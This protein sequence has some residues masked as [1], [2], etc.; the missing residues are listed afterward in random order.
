MGITLQDAEKFF[1]QNIKTF[2]S[3]T[4][5]ELAIGQLDF[6]NKLARYDSNVVL[7][8]EA[9]KQ[10]Y[11]QLLINSFWICANTSPI[12]EDQ[13]SALVASPL[14]KAE[15]A[16]T[17]GKSILYAAIDFC[18]ERNIDLPLR[19]ILQNQQ[20]L[21]NLQIKDQEGSLATDYAI[22]N[23]LTSLALKTLLEKKARCQF[24]Y[25][26]LAHIQMSLD[27]NVLNDVLSL[28]DNIN[29]EDPS[30]KQTLAN[31]AFQ[32]KNEELLF[33]MI[34]NGA[35][36][37]INTVEGGFKGLMDRVEI[38]AKR[39]RAERF[40]YH[41]LYQK[42]EIDINASLNLPKLKKIISDYDLDF[43]HVDE[44]KQ[45]FYTTQLYY[46]FREY[47]K[48]VGN[49]EHLKVIILSPFFKAMNKR[50]VEMLSDMAVDLY[51]ATS[52]NEEPLEVLLSLTPFRD[53]I[54][55]KHSQFSCNITYLPFFKKLLA[56]G[57]KLSCR[58]E[59]LQFAKQQLSPSEFNAFL[60]AVDNINDLMPTV[61]DKKN[62]ELLVL[63]HDAKVVL[64]NPD[65]MKDIDAI[66]LTLN[67]RKDA[68]KFYKNC[69]MTDTNKEFETFVISELRQ[70]KDAFKKLVA[71]YDTH[72]S[73]LDEK[74]QLH[75]SRLLIN[76]FKN[77]LKNPTLDLEHLQAITLSPY[78]KLSQS[79]EHKKIVEDTI[80][81]CRKKNDIPMQAL[82]NRSSFFYDFINNK[83]YYEADFINDELFKCC[84]KSQVK[85]HNKYEELSEMRKKYTWDQLQPVLNA[86]KNINA[87]DEKGVSL[88]QH[89]MQ[90]NDYAFLVA[91]HKA[92][93]NLDCTMEIGGIE[94][95]QEKVKEENLKLEA[96][97]FYEKDIR[98]FARFTNSELALDEKKFQSLVSEYDKQVNQLNQEYKEVYKKLILNSIDA[99]IENSD[100]GKPIN[101]LINSQYFDLLGTTN[102]KPIIHEIIRKFNNVPKS[103][104]EIFIKHK[105]ISA[106]LKI[107]D[108][109]G[110]L[111]ANALYKDSEKLLLLT[112]IG[113]KINI[114]YNTLCYI[115]NSYHFSKLIMAM[116]SHTNLQ[117]IDNHKYTFAEYA[118][119]ANDYYMLNALHRCQV[120]VKRA[121]AMGGLECVRQLKY[122][123]E[124]AFETGE[125]NTEL[126]ELLNEFLSNT[127]LFD[128][129]FCDIMKDIINNQLS[130]VT[131]Y[132]I[133][134]YHRDFKERVFSFIKLLPKEAQAYMY[135]ESIKKDTSLFKLW[136]IA[137]GSLETSPN[138]GMF[139]KVRQE[140][141]ECKKNTNMYDLENT[142]QAIS[143]LKETLLEEV[144]NYQSNPISHH[145]T[146]EQYE[147]TSL[148]KA[149]IAFS[150]KQPEFKLKNVEDWGYAFAMVG[151][152]RLKVL[153][154]KIKDDFD[155][156]NLYAKLQ[157]A[158]DNNEANMSAFFTAIQTRKI[159]PKTLHA[160]INLYP[161]LSD[162]MMHYIDTQEPKN[163]LEILTD[164][165]SPF[166]PIWNL[167]LKKVEKKIANLKKICGT[168]TNEK[169]IDSTLFYNLSQEEYGLYRAFQNALQ[170][171][172]RDKKNL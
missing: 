64:T 60:N 31:M 21:N 161:D 81:L 23:A 133:I 106:A 155:S 75:Y 3:F 94:Y 83:S 24:T 46:V 136:T 172:Q 79:D 51:H 129:Y 42:N 44:Q 17:N 137:R 142:V 109:N 107:E 166:M 149:E 120:D 45:F 146:K 70:E 54:F 100:Y 148:L 33:V 50:Y 72:I 53:Y 34:K 102:N 98:G 113:A 59:D 167:N 114:D 143:H 66:K 27:E 121:L 82:L 74:H 61:L 47:S 144:S 71:E 11:N 139:K 111:P 5:S 130:A 6:K 116:R 37:D 36:F 171:Y 22:K 162:R 86:Q 63:V 55:Q 48:K 154:N 39:K 30:S 124:H 18:K 141:L 153:K 91:L 40:F 28:H 125:K 20:V 169:Q 170:K 105:D 41:H 29:T 77:N 108:K 58:Y 57:A 89:A 128:I 145:T 84:V 62:D 95:I 93:A 43:K 87:V 10:T 115:K 157:E 92:G 164:Q 49:I 69:M 35:N 103:N 14:F 56:S 168:E 112:A 76:T 163:Q 85:L 90:N 117:M 119:M 99:C 9:K 38:A 158:L 26:E 88:A 147:K 156:I 150:E 1:D 123:E 135:A 15:T 138:R 65:V 4:P 96:E 52:K 68:E 134:C 12:R 165:S 159:S 25:D 19:A 122:Q 104:I 13:L 97:K 32:N 16:T 140:Y 151:P 132:N 80:A 131:V 118:V 2:S 127:Q 126:K 8:D 67:N 73:R 160:I 7:L 152:E 78:F 101:I 110:D